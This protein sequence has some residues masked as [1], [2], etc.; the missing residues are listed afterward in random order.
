MEMEAK[1]RQVVEEVKVMAKGDNV[2]FQR[3]M[4]RR[5]WALNDMGVH[6]SGYLGEQKLGMMT[7]KIEFTNGHYYTEPLVDRMGKLICPV[8]GATVLASDSKCEKC[9]IGLRRVGD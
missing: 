1:L 2:F 4:E 7:F 8:C 6:G 9:G 5:G 3:E